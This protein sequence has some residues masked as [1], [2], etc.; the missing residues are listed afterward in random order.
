[1]SSIYDLVYEYI[2]KFYKDQR[3]DAETK[4]TIHREIKRLLQRGWCSEDILRRFQQVDRNK[5]LSAQVHKR[6]GPHVRK[7]FNQLTPDHQNLLDPNRFYYHNV[8]RLTSS[9]PKRQLDVDSGRVIIAASEAYYLEMRDS[10]TVDDLARYFCKQFRFRE[11]QQDVGRYVGGFNW[12]L[13]H[14]DIEELLFMIDI[15]ANYCRAEK[16]DPPR[17]PMDIRRYRK[18]AMDARNFKETE[19]V[20]SGGNRIVRKKRTQSS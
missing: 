12:M 14:E 15:T 9:P 4:Q 10:F 5:A 8:L 7:L 18:E 16:Y 19:A 6:I 13:K 1:M 2:N 17:T 20:A 11:T 3:A